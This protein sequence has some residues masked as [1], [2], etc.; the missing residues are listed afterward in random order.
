MTPRKRI[1]VVEDDIIIQIFIRRIVQ[2]LGLEICGTART[3]EEA[4]RIAKDT[5]PDLVLMD[6]GIAGDTDGI[7]TAKEIRRIYD[8]PVV[9]LTGNSD[10]L[11]ME[12]ARAV[13][14]LDYIVKPVDETELVRKLRRITGS[15]AGQ[16]HNF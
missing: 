11:T 3:S 16:N 10:A 14:P 12:R 8:V 1:L 6:I 4:V 9:F 2:K 15:D 5:R 7:E 13:D